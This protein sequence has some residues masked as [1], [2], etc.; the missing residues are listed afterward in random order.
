MDSG[1]H[2]RPARAQDLPHI[3]DLLAQAMLDDELYTWMYPGRH[4]YYA[5]FRYS[6]LWRLKTGFVT[7]GYITV[8][9]VEYSEDREEIRGTAA[10]DGGFPFST[11]PE[12]WFLGQLAV[13]PAHQR[14]GIGQKLVDWGLQQARQEHV[15]VGLE[16]GVKGAGLYQK[17]GFH[18]VNMTQLT[19]GVTIRAMLY[20]Q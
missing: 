8:V 4:E 13:D 3:A 10:A 17:L 12:I 18:I 2:L 7:P 11:Y 20:T 5:D 14:R 6:F 1:I 16:A 15:P 19:S 9:A